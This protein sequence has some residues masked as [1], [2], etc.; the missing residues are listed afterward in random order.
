MGGHGALV[1]FLKNP[2][3]Y[4]SVSAFAPICNLIG[5]AWG[6]KAFGGYLGDDRDTWKQYDSCEL[7]KQYNGPPFDILAD[8]V[9]T[10][11]RHSTSLPTRSVQRPAI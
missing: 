8:Q 3:M 5:C 11:A 6:Q 10:A 7:V 4:K 9:S 1:C 2:G